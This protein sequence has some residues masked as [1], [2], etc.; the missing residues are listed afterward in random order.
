MNKL[1]YLLLGAFLAAS[2]LYVAAVGLPFTFAPGQVIKSAE[3]NANFG[4]LKQAIDAL[5]APG[6]VGPER[7]AN[8]AVTAPK[9]ATAT[10]AQNGKVLSYQNG[11]LAW[12]DPSQ[13]PAGPPGAPGPEGPPGA[14]GPAGPPGGLAGYEVKWDYVDTVF[15]YNSKK[16][17]CPS[18]KKATGGGFRLDPVPTDAGTKVSVIESYPDYNGDSYIT[19]IYFAPGGSDISAGIDLKVYAVCVSVP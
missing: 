1:K 5:E 10:P 11:Q 6:S 15:G 8:A 13:G 3:V 7:L 18:G 12:S 14:P 16:V 2:G 4:A 9:L 17:D 19:K